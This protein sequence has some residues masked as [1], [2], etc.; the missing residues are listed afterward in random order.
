MVEAATQP[1]WTSPGFAT[2]LVVAVAIVVIA[3]IFR[4]SKLKGMKVKAT[5]Q[6][7]DA[8]MSTHEPPMQEIKGN[9]LKGENNQISTERGDTHIRDNTLEGKGEKIDV[10][11]P[12]K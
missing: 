11:N 7:I 8:E 12:G 4:G 6:G 10:K 1:F 3:I 5:K 9:V 2:A